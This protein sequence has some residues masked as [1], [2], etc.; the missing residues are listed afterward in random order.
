MSPNY[1]KIATIAINTTTQHRRNHKKKNHQLQENTTKTAKNRIP[2][3]DPDRGDILKANKKRAKKNVFLDSCRYPTPLACFSVWPAGG[4]W[5]RFLLLSCSPNQLP[6][7]DID[8]IRTHPNFY[9]NTEHNQHNIPFNLQ[10]TVTSMWAQLTQAST[11]NSTPKNRTTDAAHPHA[12]NNAVTFF[13]EKNQG[14]RSCPPFPIPWLWRK[15]VA[16][17]HI[18]QVHKNYR[19]IISAGAQTKPVPHFQQEHKTPTPHFQRQLNAYNNFNRSTKYRDSTTSTGAQNTPTLHNLNTSTE[20]T[21]STTSTGG[22][23]TT[24]QLQQEHKNKRLYNFNFNCNFNSNCTLTSMGA[25]KYIDS[26]TSTGAIKNTD[27]TSS[28]G[29]QRASTLKNQHEQ[30]KKRPH[31]FNRTKNVYSFQQ[32]RKKKAL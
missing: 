7:I 15:T 27:P 23:T 28:A 2:H 4:V 32:E 1:W 14:A 20:Y 18:Q 16:P 9:F 11:K 6:L 3:F 30:R 13:W 29:A 5:G 25:P 10:F 26:T 8:K 17:T 31:K 21:D 19:L 24:P 22:Q 12:P